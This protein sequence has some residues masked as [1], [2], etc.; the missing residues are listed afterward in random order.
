MTTRDMQRS[1]AEEFEARIRD[2]PVDATGVDLVAHINFVLPVRARR[3]M[4]DEDQKLVLAMALGLARMRMRPLIEARPRVPIENDPAW[5][6]WIT[7][8]LRPLS[9]RAPGAKTLE[10]RLAEI[11]THRKWSTFKVSMATQAAHSRVAK[12]SAVCTRRLALAI[13]LLPPFALDALWLHRTRTAAMQWLRDDLR[14]HCTYVHERYLARTWLE[15]S[16]VMC[17]LDQ[18]RSPLLGKFHTCVLQQIAAFVMPSLPLPLT[19]QQARPIGIRLPRVNSRAVL[20]AQLTELA[21]CADSLPLRDVRAHLKRMYES[22]AED[23][24]NSEAQKKQRVEE[25]AP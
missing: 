17:H 5:T 8:H 20:T 11:A 25:S 3:D 15:Q 7:T 2:M 4:A 9:R 1:I 18:V 6:L 22:I 24:G 12:A 19:Q 16:N 21:G 10:Q 14:E 23:G 13:N